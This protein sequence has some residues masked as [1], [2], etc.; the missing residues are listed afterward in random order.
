MNWFTFLFSLSIGYVIYYVLNIIYDLYINT[1]KISTD[2]QQQQEIIIPL[3]SEPIKVTLREKDSN[4]AAYKVGLTTEE[5]F[6]KALPIVPIAT[7]APLS[8]KELVMLM[9][10]EV[11][12]YT[13][14]IPY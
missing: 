14:A 11:I 3:A 10:N 2:S 4:H 5:N 9:H 7:T 8:I 1:P 12:E 6:S 13:K